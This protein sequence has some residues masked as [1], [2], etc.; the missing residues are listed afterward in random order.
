MSAPGG[1]S[2]RVV[3]V[4]V[5][6][7]I[8]GAGCRSREGS[9]ANSVLSYQIKGL[10]M[11]LEPARKR[12]V[13]AHEEIPHYMKAMTMPFTVQD[14]VLL[15]GIEVGDSVKGLLVVKKS[16]AVLDSLKVI[17]KSSS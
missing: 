10:V 17:A 16:G 12:I 6:L 9:D 3:F 7:V 13:L 4:V 8:A 11:A 2:R 5:C 1:I 15:R 14:S